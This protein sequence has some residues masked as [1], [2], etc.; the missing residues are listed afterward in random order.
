MTT[1]ISDDR[2]GRVYSH[3]K[4]TVLRTRGRGISLHCVPELY[5]DEEPWS[6]CGMIQSDLA[7]E[8]RA[9]SR[10]AP[11]VARVSC[12]D[13]Q[14]VL[15]TARRL[16]AKLRGVSLIDV[17]RALHP[18]DLHELAARRKKEEHEQR[19]EKAS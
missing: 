2:K 15:Q 9:I 14:A 12:P 4:V 16:A 13:C 17:L 7:T 19:Q 3:P 6:L 1:H 18:T 8:G 10:I 11:H 5:P